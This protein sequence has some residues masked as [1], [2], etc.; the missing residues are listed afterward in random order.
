MFDCLL[1]T[2]C[3]ISS[4]PAK[5]RFEPQYR[6]EESRRLR[7]ILIQSIFVLALSLP[8][9]A[10]MLNR[11][12]YV[13]Y[14]GLA[15]G[16]GTWMAMDTTHQQIFTAW[17]T[18][19]RV[20]VLSSV[21]YHLIHS[22]IVPSPSALDISPDGTTLAVGTSGAHILFFDT[23]TF[24]KT[25][26]ILFPGAAL[27]ISGFL[28]TAN[29][30]A[31]IRA[32]MGLSTGGGVTTYWNHT[33]NAFQNT[34]IATN[35]TASAYQTTGPLAR[36]GDYSRIILGD[37]SSDGGAQVI[38]GNTGQILWS[39][40]IFGVGRGF[41]G[42]I[43]TLAANNDGSRFAVC[44][45]IPGFQE[46]LVI[47]DS[48][49]DEIYQ[50][51]NGCGGMTFSRD[52]GAL[53]RD[54]IVN[55]SVY[56]QAINMSSFSQINIPNYFTFMGA[57]YN[58]P[59]TVWGASDSTGMVYGVNF[60]GSDGG[61]AWIAF[62]TTAST[63]PTLPATTDPVHIVRV[64]DT[65]GSPQGGDTI[66]L[67]CT[68]V[69][70]VSESSISVTIAGTPATKVT[71]NGGAI[72]SIPFNQ[73]VTVKSP[74][75]SPGL[76]DVVVS[77][78]GNSDTATRAFQYANS[79]TIF[80]FASS[81][82]FLLYDRFRNLLYASHKDQVEVINVASQTL[83]SPLVPASGRLPNSQFAGLS[84]SPDG[85]RLYISDFG[86]G[87]IHVLNLNSPGTG[88]SINPTQALGGQS[89]IT[90]VRVFELS[91]GLLIGSNDTQT[92]VNYGANNIF[93]IDPGTL[94]GEWAKDQYGNT[95][96]GFLWN[97]TNGGESALISKGSLS[98]GAGAVSL[99]N[100]NSSTLFDPGA[101]TKG[102]VE[103]SANEDGTVV[104]AGG[105]TPGI[106]YSFPEIVGFDM[107][108]EGSIEN[109]FD[110]PMPTGTPSFFLHDSG[111]L[112][113]KAGATT[114]GGAG[115]PIGTVEI[116]DLHL[117][118]PA[119]SIA[120]PEAFMTSGQPPIDHMLATD[121]TGRTLFGVTQ[122]GITMIV[123]NTL[124]LSI[125][126][127]QPTLVEAPSGQTIIVRGSGFQSGATVTIGGVQ[128]ATTFVD[129]N[130]LTAQLPN[131]A[132]GWLDVT[133]TLPSG[134][135]YT[136][137]RMLQVLPS[138]PIPSVTGFSPAS[139]TVQSGI[140]GFDKSANVTILGSG[141][142]IS[143]TVEINGQLV[144]SSF[145]D[146]GH[147]QAT[148][149]S[150]L[151]GTTG[152]IS[153][154]VISAYSGS[155]NVMA[156]PMVNPVPVLMG[157]API[158][159]VPNGSLSLSLSGTGFVAG[160]VI[161]LNG[162]N[163]STSLTPGESAAGL[164]LVSA[165]TIAGPTGTAI[166]MVSNPAP[167]GG[168]S[169]PITIDIS[170][171]HPVLHMT[172]VGPNQT[173]SLDYY[174]IPSS[175]DLGTVVLNSSVTNN[176]YLQN[177][178]DAVYQLSSASIGPGTF[179]GTVSACPALSPPPASLTCVVPLTFAPTTAGATSAMLTIADNTPG[180]PYSITL[181]GV[182]VPAPV[183]AVTLN[184]I[185]SLGDTTTAALQGSVVLGGASIPA[186]A[187]IE[188]STDQSLTTYTQSPIWTQTGDGVLTGDLSQL[189]ANTVYAARF[190][191]QSA[192]GTG[193]SPIHLFST[194][195]ALPNVVL[196]LATGGSA[197]A[198]V[199]AGKTASYSLLLSD[200][201]NGYTGTAALTCT[202]AP[203]GASCTLSPSQLTV[204]TG[205]TPF[206][207]TVTTTASSTSARNNS[208]NGILT[209]AFCLLAM[210]GG[211]RFRKGL[212]NLTWALCFA[213]MSLSL[214]SCG[215]GGGG[216]GG[217]GGGGGNTGTPPGTYSL[218]INATSG[219]AQTSYSLN[220]TVQ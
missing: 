99:W 173:S 19:D 77:V 118:Q 10:S 126:N 157:N 214:I 102:T 165:N 190:A 184:R 185:D 151:T 85:N 143:D 144:S 217:G 205:Q 194:A 180:S 208:R 122:S 28:Y 79:R 175:I 69:D 71:L 189:A 66:R 14:D 150:T 112:M 119:A 105:S 192:G 134:N 67:L 23:G 127:L 129:E 153:I 25:N 76:A 201:G 156:L 178:G 58:A 174:S 22:I 21:D 120:F 1:R 55:S 9:S 136:A 35:P 36:S 125:G 29:G 3:A 168:V 172:L 216:S 210:I 62:D 142:A 220:L 91:N 211:R 51:S 140:P 42:Y 158:T 109:H 164:E 73:L 82:N 121:I 124:P 24:V 83:L 137:P 188:Y 8:S 104:V 17:L 193:K 96:G 160:T 60:G 38:D 61:T 111:A 72:S 89:T 133:V 207:V 57:N 80:P 44:V 169:N 219:I 81:P 177:I 65:V 52:G 37:A 182:G 93:L 139:I 200:G 18:L 203:I 100:A 13:P 170:T 131:T 166:V 163:L 84:L 86:A 87:L 20:D 209:L 191:V 199:T 48:S 54:A 32:E 186:T 181:T 88:T 15:G 11:S 16:P 92:S 161:Q 107:F 41:G 176:L 98:L 90:P 43:E 103:V 132:N 78:N 149:P 26:D 45:Q 39:I 202:G 159:V 30:N 116:D 97:T 141:F 154:A 204:S 94:A 212:R 187:W 75:G 101:A 135:S 218:S 171:A 6:R 68:G 195:R 50:D 115:L 4:F 31:I 53:Y 206:T 27:G 56:T 183:P 33:T 70:K 155:S 64:I 179:S 138:Q 46:D 74:P 12:T 59:P 196:S 49:F 40:G 198:T 110:V 95:I 146:S 113:Y 162:Q 47:L 63:A 128:A 148:I 167:G 117:D 145:V 130:T 213:L 7:F 2:L 106:Q 215:G 147:I 152:S 197:S 108:S 114:V 34:S 5:D 123:L